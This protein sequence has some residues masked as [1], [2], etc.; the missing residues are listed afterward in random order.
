ML[1]AEIEVNICFGLGIKFTGDIF[2]SCLYH[3]Q[4]IVGGGPKVKTMKRATDIAV[5]NLCATYVQITDLL[6]S[7][8]RVIGRHTTYMYSV[9]A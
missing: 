1:L 3:D 7:C 5:V 2:V 4:Y 9:P 8:S 6:T